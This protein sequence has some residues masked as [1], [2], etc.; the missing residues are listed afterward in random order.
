MKLK[1]LVE[2][3]RSV[4]NFV[5]VDNKKRVV[6]FVFGTTTH[7]PLRVFEVNFEDA[8][9]F[10]HQRELFSPPEPVTETV[11]NNTDL[12]FQSDGLGELVLHVFK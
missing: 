10:E 2:F 9:H 7:T 12:L 5:V 6:L 4:L 11:E 3:K 8:Q 1:E